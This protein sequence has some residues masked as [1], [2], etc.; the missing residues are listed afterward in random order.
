M[1][2]TN[3]YDRETDHQNWHRWNIGEEDGSRQMEPRGKSVA[4]K[5]GYNAGRS[6]AALLAFAEIKARNE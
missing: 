5:D 4:Y 6:N 2:Y 1:Y 3:P